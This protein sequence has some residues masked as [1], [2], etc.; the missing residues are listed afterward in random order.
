MKRCGRVFVSQIHSEYRPKRGSRQSS[1]E[2][3]QP[4]SRKRVVVT[5]TTDFPRSSV[6]KNPPANAEDS[7][8]IPGLGRLPGEESGT[9]FLPGKSHG[10]RSLVGYS[11]WDYGRVRHD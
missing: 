4:W 1:L 10:Q 9:H 2:A 7:G 8:L 11:P 3:L 6:V 5:W